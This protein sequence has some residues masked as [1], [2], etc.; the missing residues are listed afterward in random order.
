MYL[1]SENSYYT[2]MFTS[3]RTAR[4]NGYS[5]MTTKMVELA[6]TQDGSLGVD[7]VREDVVLSHI[8]ELKL[9]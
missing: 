3:A 9:L 2:V 6:K 1:D 5:L 4:D 7:S 8:K